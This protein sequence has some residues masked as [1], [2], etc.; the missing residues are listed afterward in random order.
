MHFF[1]AELLSVAQ[2]IKSAQSARRI[3]RSEGNI[4]ELWRRAANIQ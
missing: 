2:Q 1:L 3:E 4:E